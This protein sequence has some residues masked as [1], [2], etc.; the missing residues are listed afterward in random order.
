MQAIHILRAEKQSVAAPRFTPLGQ[1]KMRSIGFSV[2]GAGATV[3]VILPNQRWVLLPGA[4][5]RQFVM[6]VAAP[7]SPLKY[8]DPAL[9]AYPSAGQDECAAA[10][11]HANCSLPPVKTGL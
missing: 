6:A 7:T 8:L 4:N 11:P 2:A 1:S 5:V 10:R 3:R 9:R